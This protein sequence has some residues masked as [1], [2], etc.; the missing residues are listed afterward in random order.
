MRARDYRA[1]VVRS[2][3]SDC[4]AFGYFTPD[5]VP[6]VSYIRTDRHWIILQFDTKLFLSKTSLASP[7]SLTQADPCE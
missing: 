4:N 1:R 7:C 5:V 3:S 6:V 2:Q